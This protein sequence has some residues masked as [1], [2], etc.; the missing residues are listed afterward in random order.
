MSLSS[1]EIQS[2]ILCSPQGD[3]DGLVAFWDFENSDGITVEDKSINNN[4]ISLINQPLLSDDIPELNCIVGCT[5]PSACNYSPEANFDDSCEYV[6]CIGCTYNFACNYNPLAE[7]DDGSCL[8]ND[9]C[10]ICGGPGA[11]YECG[12]ADIPEGYCDCNGNQLDAIG[13]CGGDCEYADAIGV[14]DGDCELDENNNGICD[15]DDVYGCGIPS[16]CNY[17]PAVTFHDESCD[18]ISC[19]L[20]C[21]DAL[22]ENYDPTASIDDGSCEYISGCTDDLACNYNLDALIDDGSCEYLV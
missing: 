15:T 12:C 7:Y 10:G 22:A 21:T 18:F 16:A 11:I 4:N 9:E 13:V 2:L 14:C 20:G 5:D 1:S 17:D 3:E 6:S 19:L 8:I